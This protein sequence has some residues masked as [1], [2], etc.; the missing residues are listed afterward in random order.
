MA[1]PATRPIRINSF[2]A[3]L[4]LE[5]QFLEDHAGADPKGIEGGAIPAE[6]H[7]INP[8][9][10]SQPTAV[11][12]TGGRIPLIGLGTF[13]A[14]EK[15]THEAL[16]SALKA[17]YRHIDCASHYLNEPAIGN[18]LHAALKAGYAKREDLFITSKLWNTDHAAEDV[19]PAL[20]ATLGDLRTSYLDLYLIHWPVT[21]PQK[22]GEA[23]GDSVLL[24]H[25]P[26][27]Q[28]GG[29]ASNLAQRRA[30]CVLQ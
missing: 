1:Q 6:E 22:R 26:K 29:G 19:R 25:P 14:D 8:F 20:E 3:Q 15:T 18:G 13:K 2:Q 7:K 9:A 10:T 24:P 21:E 16:A 27:C 17:G 5:Q 4:T 28:S 11:L 30:H 12:N 23:G